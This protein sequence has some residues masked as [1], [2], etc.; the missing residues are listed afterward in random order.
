[1]AT[2]HAEN[3]S[4]AARWSVD[5]FCQMLSDPLAFHITRADAFLFGRV[6][7][8]EAELLTVVVA[9]ATRGQGI[10]RALLDAFTAQARARDATEAFLE[11]AA[12]NAPAH[13]LYTGTG[14]REAG[15]R[16]GY[17]DGTDALI[18]RKSL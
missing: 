14:W 13:A 15:R 12:D 18:L 7:A 3:F 10:G 11:V 4:G 17:Y 2:L 5:S 9:E 8:Q 1:M 16:S 6:V